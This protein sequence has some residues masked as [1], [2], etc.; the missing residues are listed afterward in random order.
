[1]DSKPEK[2][3]I[4][5]YSFWIHPMSAMKCACLS[6]DLAAVLVPLMTGIAPFVGRG[7]DLTDKDIVEAAP[8]IA[9]AFSTLSGEKIEKLMHALLIDERKIGVEG[10]GLKNATF[11]DAS[12]IDTVF[13]G[14]AQNMFILAFHVINTNFGDFFGSLGPQ[15]GAALENLK[16]GPTMENTVS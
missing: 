7:Q 6:G 10:P 1:M 5:G 12:N 8:A 4:G 14:H 13:A 16:K 3:E 15:F 9:G 11:L 2:K